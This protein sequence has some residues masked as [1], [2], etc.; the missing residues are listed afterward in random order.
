MHQSHFD[1]SEILRLQ[2]VEDAVICPGS[3]NAP[4]IISFSRNEH[5]Q[6]YSFLD[7]RSG[8]YAA[9]GMALAKKK[10]V[11]A[12]CTSGTA[13]LNFG[14]A[15]A[16]S[17]YQRIP[18][19]LISGDR[20]PSWT[21]QGD[22][23]TIRQSGTLGSHVKANIDLPVD[24]DHPDAQWEYRRKLQEAVHIATTAPMGPVHLNIPFREPFYPDQGQTLSFTGDLRKRTT[25]MSFNASVQKEDLRELKEH[26]S[27]AKKKIIVIGQCQFDPVRNRLLSAL[28]RGEGI[29]IIA[30]VTANSHDISGDIVLSHDVFLSNRAIWDELA[31]DLVLTLGGSLI[32][33]HLKQFL[34]A[35]ANEHWHYSTG[36]HPA[37]DTFQKLTREMVVEDYSLLAELAEGSNKNQT[38][39]NQWREIDTEA[40]LRLQQFAREA[41]LSDLSA[42]FHVIRSLPDHTNLHLANSMAVRYVNFLGIAGKKGVGVY[43]NRGTSGIDGSNSTALGISMVTKKP[44]VLLTGDLSLHYDRNAFLHGCPN[45]FK[46]IVLNN[47]EG[48]IFDLIKGPEAMLA[49]EKQLMKTP[50][51]SDFRL[52]AEE[53]GMAYAQITSLQD[54]D[55]SLKQFWTSNGPGLLEVNTTSEVNKRVFQELKKRI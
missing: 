24:L 9:M 8:A 44:N 12:C 16:E 10:P 26:W 25:L 39:A 2:G 14:P 11:V 28:A 27:Q 32:S 18:L 41:E 21:D 13:L 1:T 35:H 3:R 37:T 4:L 17:F 19:I 34:R 31:P 22:G 7:E 42:T 46:V 53:A 33:K 20:P 55:T 5:I 23:Q 36:D 51:H 52:F 6:T 29:P 40:R 48:G 30:D 45:N 49:D 38:Y 54:M 43:A 47:R 50:H 15:A